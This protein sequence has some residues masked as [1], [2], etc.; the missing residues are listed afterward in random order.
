MAD[1]E[2]EGLLFQPHTSAGRLPTQERLKF[3]VQHIMD[4]EP[5][6]WGEQVAIEQEMLQEVDGFNEILGKTAQLLASL[7]G[8]AAIVSS[9]SELEE[10]LDF[11]EFVRI[12]PHLILVIMVSA[13]GTVRNQ[14]IRTR[15]DIRQQTLERF[16]QRMNELLKEASLA[17]IRDIII[18]S[19]EEDRRIFDN[20]LSQLVPDESQRRLSG[21]LYIDGKLNLLDEPEFSHIPKLKNLL[22]TLEEKHLLLKLLDKCLAGDEMQILIGTEVA[23]NMT[24]CGMV[25]APYESNKHPVGSLGVLGPMRMNYPRVVSLVE[26]IAAIL[27]SRCKEM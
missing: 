14:L 8:Y 12:K 2:D 20:I 3:F 16:N 4:K 5:L 17:E 22:E 9:P 6:S 27:S 21:K 7:T 18:E 11:V 1:L 24:E 25:V 19:M 23:S 13:S 15:R 26:Y 10:H